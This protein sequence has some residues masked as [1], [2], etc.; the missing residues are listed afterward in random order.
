MEVVNNSDTSKIFKDSIEIDSNEI[1]SNDKDKIPLT[2]SVST[3]SV[4]PKSAFSM[5]KK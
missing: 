1:N 5:N 4:S 2:H 3:F